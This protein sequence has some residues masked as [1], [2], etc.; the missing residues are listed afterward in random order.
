V[1]VIGRQYW[2]EVRYL[3]R[4]VVTANE[5][6]IPAGRAVR[7]R[8][9]SA[10]VIHSFW[11]PQLA[12]KL[13]LIPG[14]TNTLWIEADAPGI[15][16]GQCAEFCGVQHA[17]MALHVVAV[18]PEQFGAWLEASRGPAPPPA[19]ALAR[20]GQELF[21][22][23]ACAAC[24][25]VRGTDADGSA[26]PDLTHLM[27]RQWIA[28]GTL[29]NTPE[30]LADFITDAQGIKRGSSMPSFSE[31]DPESLRALIAY[32]TTLE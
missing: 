30:N 32:L 19:D 28:A 6:H 9:T 7:L 17:R 29:R 1:D 23:R 10:D 12:G 20:R 22:S 24:H 15:Y 4:G 16:R 3:D 26:G 27:R 21:F 11:V 8:L 18:P 2:W 13:D 31:L 5:V 25:A 14:Q